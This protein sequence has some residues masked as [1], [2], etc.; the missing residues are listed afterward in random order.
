MT[1]EYI[2]DSYKMIDEKLKLGKYHPFEPLFM[3]SMCYL[4]DELERVQKDRDYWKLS[5]NKQ[6]G[7]QR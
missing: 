4:Y 3:Q 5:F 7:A 6:V 2:S 1:R